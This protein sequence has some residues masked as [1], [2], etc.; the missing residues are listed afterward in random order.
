MILPFVTVPPQ[1]V[2]EMACVLAKKGTSAHNSH[3]ISAFVSIFVSLLFMH[4]FETFRLVLIILLLCSHLFTA[5]RNGEKAV[6]DKCEKYA[7]ASFH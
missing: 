2:W 1:P 7:L 6:N 3:P 4:N 5:C